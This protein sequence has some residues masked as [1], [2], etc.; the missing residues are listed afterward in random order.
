VDIILKPPVSGVITQRFGENVEYYKQWGYCCGHNGIDWGIANGTQVRAAEDGKVVY[1]GYENGGYGNYIKLEHKGNGAFYTYY[2]H[3]RDAVVSVGDEVKAG[4]MIAY[5][6]NTGASTGPHLHFGLKVPGEN[7]GMKGYVDPA[8]Y[9]NLSPHEPPSIGQDFILINSDFEVMVDVLNVRVG[10]GTQYEKVG[11]LK[12]GTV[13]HCDA[14]TA[15][16][17]G[18]MQIWMRIDE[19]KYDTYWCAGIY[20]GDKY[21][22]QIVND[23]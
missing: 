3:L 14:L 1:I 16:C 19:V 4:D 6:D 21:L 2:A 5:S 7:P 11:T 12:G 20:N 10:A 17:S 22:R 18:F 15:L 8:P 23:N 13:I 9:F